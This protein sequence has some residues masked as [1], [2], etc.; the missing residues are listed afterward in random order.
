MKIIL[1]SSLLLFSVSA[2][3]QY[4]ASE[5]KKFKI[6]KII[7]TSVSENNP[8]ENEVYITQYDKNGNETA[9]FVGDR[10]STTTKYEYS[11]QGKILKSV[12]YQSD[13]KEIENSV[14]TYAADGSYKVTTTDKD[15]GLVDYEWYNAS[16]KKTKAQSPDGSQRIY[17]YDA[18][19][20]LTGIKTGNK[21]EGAYVVDIRFTYNNKNQL[22]RELNKGDYSWDIK[23]EYNAKGLIAKEIKISGGEDYQIKTTTEYSYEFY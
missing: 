19:G 12:N 21:V 11:A 20:N 1:L 5:I 17:S 18:K 13:G 2:A 23:Y 15:F 10:P 3:A 4:T 14:Y 6:S 22:V 7:M 9:S 8:E 16:G